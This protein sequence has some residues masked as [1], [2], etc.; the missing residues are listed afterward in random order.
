MSG[1]KIPLDFSKGNFYESNCLVNKGNDDKSIEKSIVDFITLLVNSPNSS[2]KPDSNFGFSLKNCRFE[3]V[4]SNDKI[5]DKTIRGKSE[6]F[7]YAKD[8]K[9]AITQFEP[10]LQNLKVEINFDKAHSKGSIFISGILKSTK[11]EY[12][13]DIKFHIWRNNEDI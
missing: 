11:K 4:D 3:N 12:K 7:N 8:L 6:N 5:Q 1:F 13:Q 2:F 9:D 10:R